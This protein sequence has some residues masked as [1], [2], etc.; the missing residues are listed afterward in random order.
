MQ[1]NNSQVAKTEEKTKISARSKFSA[2]F[3]VVLCFLFLFVAPLVS[4]AQSATV[5]NPIKSESINELIKTIIEAVVKIGMP[6]I[7]LA[8]IYSGFLFI[9]ARGKPEE[10]KKAAETL[11]YT[12]IGAAIFLGAWAIAELIVE[13]ITSL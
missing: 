7:V 3:F 9:K 10:I 12:L 8:I 11:Q 5:V 6:V 2:L 13:T 4:S 1:Y